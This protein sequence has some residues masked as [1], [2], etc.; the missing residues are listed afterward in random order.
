M[1]LTW[2]ISHHVQLVPTSI[3]RYK[4]VLELTRLTSLVKICVHNYRSATTEL[5]YKLI[6]TRNKKK[7]KTIV[8]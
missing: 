1:V 5:E 2:K 3:I 8:V 7:Q 6:R 4:N